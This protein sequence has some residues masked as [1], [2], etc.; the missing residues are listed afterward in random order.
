MKDNPEPAIVIDPPVPLGACIIWLHG[1]GADGHDFEPIIADLHLPEELGVRFV[2]PH[3]PYR[4]VTINGGYLM[5]AW[6]DVVS[7]DLE[8]RPDFD[9]ISASQAFLE[10]LIEQQLEQGIPL[11]RLILAGFS[12]GGVIALQTALA[13]DPKPA[14]VLAL[15][16]YLA[17]TS[18]EG[19][20]L[21]VFQAHGLQDN[22]VPPA[23]ARRS[24]TALESLGAEVAWHEYPM[25]HS[26]HPAEVEDISRW[27]RQRL[28][29]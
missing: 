24:R 16:T 22:V 13:M 4:P 12:Q 18:G 1:L 19:K 3:A 17:E 27:L 29:S 15:S 9:G 7:A 21:F 28:G 23:A 5:R 6:Y 20:G 14:G 2:F 26:L 11:D 25:P 10:E 8:S